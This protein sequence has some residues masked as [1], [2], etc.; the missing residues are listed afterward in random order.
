MAER[1]LEA[2]QRGMWQAPGDY[3]QALQNL[4]LDIDQQQEGVE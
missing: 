2:T 4:L 3:A 1:L